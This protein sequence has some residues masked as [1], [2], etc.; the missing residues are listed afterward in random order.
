MFEDEQHF[1]LDCPA[2]SHLRTN[3][4]S[5]VQQVCTVSDFM[6]KYEPNACGGF[7]RDCFS[8]RKCLSLLSDS[9]TELT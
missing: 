5:L 1:I 2:Y 3:H 4:A 7:I 8:H 6:A 9:V